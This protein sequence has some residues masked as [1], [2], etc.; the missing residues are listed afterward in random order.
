VLF[1]GLWEDTSALGRARREVTRAL[2]STLAPQSHGHHADYDPAVLASLPLAS[3]SSPEPM[4]AA[5]ELAGWR[6][7]R[8]ARLH[9]VEWARRLAGPPVIGTLEGRPQFAITA[10]A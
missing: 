4:L 5:V 6:R 8:I 7:V 10:D 9:D 2:R 3:M 1:E